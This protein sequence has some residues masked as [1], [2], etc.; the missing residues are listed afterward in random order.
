MS[1]IGD[2][3]GAYLLSPRLARLRGFTGRGVGSR[4]RRSYLDLLVTKAGSLERFAE[5]IMA[6]YTPAD[7]GISSTVRRA[8]STPKATKWNTSRSV[9]SENARRLGFAQL[10]RLLRAP[11][12][13][14]GA[15]PQPRP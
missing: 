11:S 7:H 10:G 9:I 14:S 6:P 4:G 12:V 5:V 13:T 1:S 2:G 15:T 8:R 3:A